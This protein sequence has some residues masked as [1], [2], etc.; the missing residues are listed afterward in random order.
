[1]LHFSRLK[2]LIILG[3][4]IVGALFALPNVLPQD[5]RDRLPGWMPSNT[6]VLG[7]DLQGGS[8]ILLEVDAAALRKARVNSVRDDIRNLLREMRVGYTGLGVTDTGVQVQLRD[9]AD[10]ARVVQRL[11][12]MASPVSSIVFGAAAVQDLQV[13]SAPSGQISVTLT[14]EGI[15][16]RVRTAVE[17]SVEI[18]RRRI[19]QLGTTEPNIQ[20]QGAD[21][22]LVQVPGLDD[23]ER[24]KGLLGQTAQLTF[25]LVDMTMSAEQ[26][27]QTRPPEESEVLMSMDDPPVPYLVQRQ[28]MVAGE[29]LID[30]RPGF[31][32]RNGQPVVN[33]RFNT[34]GAQRF[35]VV[36]QQNVNRPFAIVL[37]N[38]VVSAPVIN[39]PILGGSGQISGNFTVQQANDFAILLRSGALPAPLK[40]VEERT[41]GPGL[42]ADSIE[43]G[44]MA[45]LIGAGAVVLFMIAVYGTFGV[46]A[47]LAVGINVILIFGAL[48]ALGATLTLPGIAGIVLTVGMAVD[49]NVLIFER[50]R[51]E[52]QSGRS[53]IS[54][55]EFG[56]SKA[57]GTIIDSNVTSFITAV[58][59]F[60][61]GG[62][63]PVRGFAVTYGIGIIATVFTAYSLTS[64]IIAVWVRTRRPSAVPI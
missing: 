46:F 48:S 40:V 37:D 38:E 25:R 2:M 62:S 22:I 64:L 12:E 16:E 11:Q 35:G 10:T 53:A 44:E 33:F 56:F 30:A 28:I 54:A 60:L 23:P 43:A 31:D 17:Q 14:P 52:A 39:E 9:E 49:S 5:V 4:T 15:D 18:V 61:L 55:I 51:E 24:L 13:T 21:R 20:R 58:V 63:G 26:A 3:I 41:I 45:A 34:R 27:M 7:L 47:V 36:T 19:D 29:D 59:L 42:G 1:M 50:I 32:Q 8:H 57:L 6:I